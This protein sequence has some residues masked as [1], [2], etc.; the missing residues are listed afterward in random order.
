VN[1]LREVHD[2]EPGGKRTHEVARHIRRPALYP[3]EQLG[4]GFDIAVAT[5]DGGDAV[6]LNE[7]Q[8]L[9]AALLE[10][11]FPDQ[12]TERMHIL[13][14]RFVLRREIDLTAEHFDF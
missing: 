11:D 2:V 9:G 12:R 7:V 4:V 14:K 13:A 1:L 8:E 5:L 6:L 3:R 10:Q